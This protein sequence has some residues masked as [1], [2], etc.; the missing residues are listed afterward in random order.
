MTFVWPSLLVLSIVALVLMPALNVMLGLAAGS[1][2]SIKS[3]LLWRTRS[4]GR[5]PYGMLERYRIFVVWISAMADLQSR[6]IE[7]YEVLTGPRQDFFT[8]MREEAKRLG[9]FKVW[10]RNGVIYARRSN[11]SS[12]IR[13]HEVADI[14]SLRD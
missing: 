11:N 1:M 4:S 3:L 12:S 6:R 2:D 8:K 5:S 14:S 7:M 10:H 9:I 13:V